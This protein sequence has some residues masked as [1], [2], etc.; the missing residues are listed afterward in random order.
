[1][2][3]YLRFMCNG[4]DGT[5]PEGC[6]MTSIQVILEDAVTD[7]ETARAIVIGQLVKEL[8]R[9]GLHEALGGV[10]IK[11]HEQK[12]VIVVNGKQYGELPVTG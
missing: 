6:S 12:P 2:P 11:P 8:L 3:K 10:G 4:S 9:Y 1:M 5:K 7:F